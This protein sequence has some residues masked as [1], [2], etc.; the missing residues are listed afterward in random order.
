MPHEAIWF[1]NELVEVHI[2][3]ADTGG[4]YDVVTFT[5]PPGDMPPPHIHAN[6][7]EGVLVLEG[8]LTLHTAAGPHV[9][10]AGEAGHLPLGEPHTSEVTSPGPARLVVIGVPA[11]FADFVRAL[12]TPAQRLELPVEDGEP[13][14]ERLERIALEHGISFV[15]PP[16]SLPIELTDRATL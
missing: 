14:L 16:G 12:G 7:S 10:R 4:A 13:D 9:V 3:G 6:E 11:G 8:E 2:D 5:S 1:L 15:G